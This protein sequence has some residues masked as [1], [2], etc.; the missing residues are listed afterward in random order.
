MLPQKYN[1][2]TITH[3]GKQQEAIGEMNMRITLEATIPIDH[4]DPESFI[5]PVLLKVYASDDNGDE[6]LVG[7]LYADMIFVGLA[8]NHGHRLIDVFDC[9]EWVMVYSAFFND[10]EE[11]RPELTFEDPIDRVLIFYRVFLAPCTTAFHREIFQRVFQY[12]DFLTLIGIWN[13]QDAISTSDLISLG[14]AKLSKNDMVVKHNALKSPF[15]DEKPHPDFP[16]F[17]ANESDE[18]WVNDK[19]SSIEDTR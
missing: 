9:D 19:V 6:W 12:L 14:F 13:V 11:W 10:R 3:V 16:Y 1:K 2:C 4:D 8:E 18:A 5:E 15:D 7:Q 17:D